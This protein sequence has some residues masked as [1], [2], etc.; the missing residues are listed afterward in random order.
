[1]GS[2]FHHDF[3]RYTVASLFLTKLPG[4]GK[5]PILAVQAPRPERGKSRLA[6]L[7]LEKLPYLMFKNLNS[8]QEPLESARAETAELQRVAAERLA[9]LDLKDAEL[10]RVRAE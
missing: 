6:N 3:I 7:V 1:P 2:L 5:K 4:L 10:S 9:E 8:R